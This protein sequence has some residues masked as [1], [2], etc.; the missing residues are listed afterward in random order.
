MLIYLTYVVQVV[1]VGCFVYTMVYISHASG[2]R[3]YGLLVST[4]AF[5]LFGLARKGLRAK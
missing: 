1:A 4:L 5:I 3:W 2:G